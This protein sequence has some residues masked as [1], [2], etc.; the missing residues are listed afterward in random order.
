MKKILIPVSIVASILLCTS[1]IETTG[2][3]SPDHLFL[4]DNG[5]SLFV[6]NRAGSELLKMSSD[7]QDRELLSLLR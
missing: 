5:K 2:T 6:T 4:A 1:G 3:I 7:G